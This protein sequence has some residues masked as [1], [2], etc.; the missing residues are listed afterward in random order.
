[1]LQGRLCWPD[2]RLFWSGSWNCCSLIHS[3]SFINCSSGFKING[4]FN[5]CYIWIYVI[6]VCAVRPLALL[7]IFCLL[8]FVIVLSI[9]LQLW[10]VCSK[11]RS[12]TD[13]VKVIWQFF[14]ALV[15]KVLRIKPPRG[16]SLLCIFSNKSKRMSWVAPPTCKIVR[17]N[18]PHVGI[19]SC[20]SSTVIWT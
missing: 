3:Y 9:S 4:N 1:L 11:V 7:I 18:Y 12:L 2:Q 14:S 6:Y 16:S 17:L 10:I 8:T 13:T 20:W 19:K 15:V 5:I